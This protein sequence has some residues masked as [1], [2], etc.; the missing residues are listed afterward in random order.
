MNIPSSP[1]PDLALLL[2]NR[3]ISRDFRQSLEF[4][5]HH[6]FKPI[7]VGDLAQVSKLSRRGLF[8]AFLR[9]TGERPGQI[10]RRIRIQRAQELLRSSNWPIRVVAGVCGFK[11]VN[12]FA[13]AFKRDVGVS[14]GA[15]RQRQGEPRRDRSIDS[16][17]S[18]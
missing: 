10:L 7:N 8:K 9:H 11:R 16:P 13:V 17:R 15:Y 12:S 6:W 3:R 5:H 4:L 18:L 1:L 2:L 14:P